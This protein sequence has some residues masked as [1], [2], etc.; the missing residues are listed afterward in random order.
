[1][2]GGRLAQL[3]N[4]FIQIAH[5]HGDQ[6]EGHVRQDLPALA[7]NVAARHPEVSI[8]LLQAVGENDAVLDGIATV[9]VA[10]LPA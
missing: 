1:M 3:A 8:D 4:G 2:T 6:A 7:Q 5:L 10:G 9:C